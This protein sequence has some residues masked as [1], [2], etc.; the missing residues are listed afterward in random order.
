MKKITLT[1]AVAALGLFATEAIA[2]DKTAA[3]QTEERS[4]ENIQ[5]EADVLKKRITDYAAKVEANR[6]NETVDY[7]AE[8]VRISEMKAQWEELTGKS[9]E[10][11]E[12][13]EKM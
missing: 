1:L 11:Q 12:K 4:A 10:R 3:V 5:K 13:V 2:Q 9:W 7:E 8:Q 6:S